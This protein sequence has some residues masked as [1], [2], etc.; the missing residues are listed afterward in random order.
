MEGRPLS[1]VEKS[2]PRWLGLL[3]AVF[4]ACLSLAS[5]ATQVLAHG[6]PE[7]VRAAIGAAIGAGTLLA[8]AYW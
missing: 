7:G 6:I 8:V 5:P 3:V 1:K 4:H 2:R